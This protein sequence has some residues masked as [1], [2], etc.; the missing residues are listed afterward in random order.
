MFLGR[1]KCRKEKWQRGE[2]KPQVSQQIR[3]GRG[4]ESAEAWRRHSQEDRGRSHRVQGR[5]TFKEG[6]I[7]CP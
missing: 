3:G 6:D 5:V 7:P 4:K 1:I 2:D